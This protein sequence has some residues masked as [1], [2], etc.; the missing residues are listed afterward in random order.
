MTNRGKETVAASSSGTDKKSDD[1]EVNPAQVVAM[2]Q[3]MA[4]QFQ[5]SRSFS[6]N[7][8]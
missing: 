3:T 2:M 4:E 8:D 6:E 7:L 1:N 5:F